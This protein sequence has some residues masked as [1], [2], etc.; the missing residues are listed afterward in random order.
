MNFADELRQLTQKRKN[1]EQ[2]RIRLTTLDF[3]DTLKDKLK[4]VAS[5]GK[6]SYT[7]D[8]SGRTDLS[9]PLIQKELKA[10]GITTQN[11]KKKKILVSKTS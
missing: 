2:D 9:I 3:V 5:K 1:E 6:D 8:L 10:N 7:V 11:L 4:E